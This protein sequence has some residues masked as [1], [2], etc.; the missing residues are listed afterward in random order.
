MYTTTVQQDVTIHHKFN[1]G[2]E[3]RR[4]YDPYISGGSV[5][6]TPTSLSHRSDPTPGYSS[7]R[8]IERIAMDSSG[9][10]RYWFTIGTWAS[11]K[12]VDEE[13]ELVGPPTSFVRDYTLY[14]VGGPFN[15]DVVKVGSMIRS[16]VRPLMVDAETIVNHR[17]GV[18]YGRQLRGAHFGA[19]DYIAIYEGVE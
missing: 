19:Q 18:H 15:G 12:S 8:V 16:Y 9:N 14:L 5:S 2:D 7:S 11:V 1:V 10:P 13:W 6:H 17:Y 3:V 4:P